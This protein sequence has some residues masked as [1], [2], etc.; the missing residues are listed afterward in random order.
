MMLLLMMKVMGVGVL[1]ESVELVVVSGFIEHT[2]GRYRGTGASASGDGSIDTN[3]IGR[4]GCID[5]AIVG[6]SICC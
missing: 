2:T 1:T 4:C 5:S 3:V 6:G